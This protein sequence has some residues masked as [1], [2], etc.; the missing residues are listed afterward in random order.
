LSIKRKEIEDAPRVGR[1]V[2]SEIIAQI[3]SNPRRGGAKAKR[4]QVLRLGMILQVKMNLQGAATIALHHALH[5]N[6]L[7]QKVKQVSH[8]LVTIVIVIA[9]MKISPL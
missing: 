4:S 8:P 7:W 2:T 9:M 1:R 3:W 5:A 6:A